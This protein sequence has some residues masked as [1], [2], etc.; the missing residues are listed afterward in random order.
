MTVV[1]G[2]VMKMLFA[3]SFLVLLSIA[4]VPYVGFYVKYCCCVLSSF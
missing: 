2:H 3:F 1:F 4:P